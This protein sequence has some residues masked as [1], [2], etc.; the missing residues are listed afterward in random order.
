MIYEYSCEV[1]GRFF[2]EVRSYQERNNVYCCGIQAAKLISCPSTDKDKAY[3]FTTEMF[4]GKP[5]EITSKG[6]YKRLLKQHHI[7]DASIKEC[8]QQADKCR[9][10]N[11][12]SH[13]LQVRQ[14]AKV[15]GEKLKQ[16]NVVKEGREILTKLAKSGRR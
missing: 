12:I 16:A 13:Q 6:Q 15:V 5:V 8:H 2:E 10:N 7:A 9:R 3:S 4:D 1:C 14:R 11:E